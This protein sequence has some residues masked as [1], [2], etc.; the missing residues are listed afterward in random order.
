MEVVVMVGVVVVMLSLIA[1]SAEAGSILASGWGGAESCMA[2]AAAVRA[3]KSKPPKAGQRDLML[4]LQQTPT[5]KLLT[6]AGYAAQ[7]SVIM[8][9]YVHCLYAV[10]RE[11]KR[12]ERDCF[13]Q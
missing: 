11:W 12:R 2:A 3:M 1:S 10:K 9:E 13:T 7:G 4:H 5:L 6:E 8:R